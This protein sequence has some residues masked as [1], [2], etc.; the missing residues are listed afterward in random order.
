MMALETSLKNCVFYRIV[1]LLLFLMLWPLA[2]PKKSMAQKVSLHPEPAAGVASSPPAVNQPRPI[3]RSRWSEDWSTLRNVAPFMMDDGQPSS[4]ELRNPLKYIPLNKSGNSYLNLGGE[5]RL[6]Y[7]QYDQANMGIT[8]TGRQDSVQHRAALHADLHLNHQFR[9][10][11]QLG[12]ASVGDREGG[13]K[14]IDE[15][16]VDIWQLFVDSRF[17]VDESERVVFRLGRQI[18]ETANVFI[19]AGEAHNVRLY[20]DGLRL[21]WIDK[22]DNDFVKFEAFAAEYVDYADGSFDM[23]GTDEYFW[24]F[25]VGK[26]FHQPEVNLTFHYMG[27]DLKDRQFEQG[28]AGYHDERRHTLMLWLNRPLIGK[29]QLG[30]DYYLAYQLGDY[31]EQ[32]GDSDIRA[33]AAF[34]ELKYALSAQTR[35]PILGL[36]TSYF[37]GDSGPDDG[38]LNTFYNPVFGT[39]YFGYA[40]DIMPFNLIH[41]QPSVGYRFNDRALVTLSHGFQW[42]A[43]KEDGY[44]NSANG[45]T[46][47]AGESNSSWLGQQTQLAVNYKPTENIVL[48]AYLARFFAGDFIDDAGGSDRDYAH[49]SVNY[50]F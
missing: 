43:E 1:S 25:S 8:D 37:S 31:E 34:G 3:P 45:I 26:R 30:L 46:V 36:K 9:F 47:R 28:G 39:P 20:Y 13:K 17:D 5:Y 19:T 6:A 32:S 33:F 21:G 48:L 7:E 16:E 42:R 29:R 41:I 35:T 27:W 14:A 2:V 49:F 12:Y 38:E 11:G 50:L 44:Y 10:F 4:G 24:G 18:I 23:A 22:S 15:T 40:R